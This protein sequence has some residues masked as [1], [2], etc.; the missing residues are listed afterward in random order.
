MHEHAI[1]STRNEHVDDVNALMIDR[2]P[3]DKHVYYSFDEVEDDIRNNYPL[4][5]F[6]FFNT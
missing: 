6:Q 2:F 5:F 3:G 1:L 4:D